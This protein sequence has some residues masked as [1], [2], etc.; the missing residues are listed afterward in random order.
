MSSTSEALK[1]LFPE[2]PKHIH[3]YMRVRLGGFGRKLKIPKEERYTVYKCMKPG[4]KHYIRV[5][6]VLGQF[7]ECWRCGKIMIMN[8]WSAT[9]KKPH[10]RDCTRE[11]A[12]EAA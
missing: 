1:D 12:G 9:F 11:R 6:L 10:C 7:N 3:K 4:C 5:E 8:Q 2:L